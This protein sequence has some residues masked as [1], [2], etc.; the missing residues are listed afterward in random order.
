[1][2]QK[3]RVDLCNMSRITSNK[4]FF[5]EVK[6]MDHYSSKT[7]GIRYNVIKTSSHASLQVVKS[8]P[9]DLVNHIPYNQ[10]YIQRGRESMEPCI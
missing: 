7:L 1:M 3:P 10:E 9:V 6:N 2:Q 4:A 8:I 5:L